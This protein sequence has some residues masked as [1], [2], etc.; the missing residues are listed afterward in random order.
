VF[1]KSLEEKSSFRVEYRFQSQDGSYRWLAN[2]GKP[3]YNDHGKPSR[4]IGTVEDI[5]ERRIADEWLR[6]RNQV[7]QL[8]A[9]GCPVDQL[10][11]S[12]VEMV[13]T[14]L[15]NTT[16]VLLLTEPNSRP[17]LIARQPLPEAMLQATH[18]LYSSGDLRKLHEV[19]G[20]SVDARPESSAAADSLWTMSQFPTTDDWQHH[21]AAILDHGY[22][23]FCSAPL[24][25]FNSPA[26]SQNLDRWGWLII[27]RRDSDQLNDAQRLRC[28]QVVQ[29]VAIAV[30]RQ[31]H[32]QSLRESEHRFRELANSVPQLVW[33]TDPDGKCVY[34]NQLLKDTIGPVGE[35]DWLSIVHPDDRQE[36]A[37]R[38][39]S[40]VKAGEVYTCEHR[41][42]V[43]RTGEYRWY[44]ARA[45]ASRNANGDIGGWYG[46]AADIDDLKRT[47]AT[48]REER[49]RISAIAAASPGVIFSCA[50]CDDGRVDI[51][52][53]APTF[54]DLLGIAPAEI[55]RDPA[56]LI[57]MLAPDE[58]EMIRD[59]A[60]RSASEMSPGA[61]TFQLEHPTKGTIWIECQASPRRDLTG[62]IHWHGVLTDVT[63]RKFLEKKL[64]QSE[65]M[66][67]IGRLAGGIAHD[68]NNLLTVILGSCE[69]LE[70]QLPDRLA[71][72]ENFEAIQ[73]AS[74][75]AARLTRQLLTFSRQREALPQYVDPNCVI[76]DAHLILQRLVG[77]K[78]F[79][80]PELATN[81]NLVHIDPL[82][83]EQVMI[84]L[85]VNAR[86]AMHAGGQ[87]I[88]ST[89]NIQT[90]TPHDRLGE[91][92]SV[93]RFVEISV[94]D[95]GIGIHP[96]LQTRVF[97]PFF[98]TKEPGKGTGL[99][100]AVVHG[101][102]SQC[103]GQVEFE[104][105]VGQ[106]TT[107]RVLLP[108]IPAVPRHEN[109]SRH[110]HL[111]VDGGK[112]GTSH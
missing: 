99:G 14:A 96:E 6:T 85:V 55:T 56:P 79:I 75:R 83:L 43:H 13:E 62:T 72:R 29:L 50:Y 12:L 18:A 20:D 32:E 95:T 57:K 5:T 64:L 76:R 88:I 80:I 53:A 51:S 31:R 30:E 69:L 45:S 77:S 107:V 23:N 37:C 28:T 42:K 26:A 94:S 111:G 36:V 63:Q 54:T 68:F 22:H 11:D 3:Y 103:G 82:Q 19:G 65:R 81:I 59:A 108:A 27:L 49:D 89:R 71:V 67:A 97:E 40:A 93:S 98:T 9:A 33:T 110:S 58:L 35:Q 61:V 104:S 70:P 25:A 24:M 44:L 10:N 8:I 46:V 15:P 38:F 73:Q 4:M 66:E 106:G 84:N 47:E 109:P 105:K 90:P 74:F 16:A 21:R 91:G 39:E 48:L 86:D 92:N 2:V 87:I 78:V 100:L 52:Y 34:S 41:L 112:A 7:L 101:V 60:R 17:Q 1:Y 102:V